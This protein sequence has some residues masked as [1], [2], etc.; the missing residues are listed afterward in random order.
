MSIL[1]GLSTPTRRSLGFVSEAKTT[2]EPRLAQRVLLRDCLRVN[3]SSVDRNEKC[4]SNTCITLT[5]G[6]HFE[7]SGVEC[8]KCMCI[9]IGSEIPTRLREWR[10]AS[11]K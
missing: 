11:A 6:R 1:T 8:P 9:R 7:L 10:I 3:I 4:R 2:Q 5:P